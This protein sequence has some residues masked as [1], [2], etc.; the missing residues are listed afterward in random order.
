MLYC[1]SY[2]FETVIIM[3]QIVEFV[4]SYLIF[5]ET[6]LIVISILFLLFIIQAYFYLSYYRKPIASLKKAKENKGK[7]DLSVSIIIVSRNDSE[8]LEQLLPLLLQQNYSNFEVIVVN[9]GS[10]DESQYYV[11]RLAK[12]DERIY[13][14]FSPI[15]EDLSSDRRRVLAMTIGIKAAKND[16]LLFTEPSCRPQN[17]N[18]IKL[19]ANSFDSN[20]DI[21][22][23]Y[24]KLNPPHKFWGRVCRFDNLLFSLQYLS[25]ALKNKPF[26]GTYRNIAYQKHLFFD[27]K[28][29]SSTLNFSNS[30]EIFLNRIMTDSNT[31]IMMLPDSFTKT[32]IED[33]RHWK[34]LKSIYCASKSFFK[35]H[36]AK[37]FSF[38]T[39]SRYLFYIAFV[40]AIVYS[41]YTQLWVYLIGAIVL[42]LVRNFIQLFILKSASKHFE[43]K[44]F[45]FS[46]IILDLF[47]P[48]YNFIFYNYSRHK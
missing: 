20:T 33:Y 22:L 13:Y 38:E 23:A 8:N 10:T 2:L 34:N 14:T 39:I 28:G 32:K 7:D 42:F 18:W 26:I 16:V 19:M 48:L 12:T 11:E 44:P 6:S 17:D 25:M 46:L 1:T 15:S 31:A 29:F 5:D 36:T 3:N 4:S 41:I 30:E 45:Y 24:N 21:I 40:A 47:Q 9:D 35:G 43:N 27:H 37:R